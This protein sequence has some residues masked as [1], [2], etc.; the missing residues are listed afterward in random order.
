[1]FSDV[2]PLVH[3]RYLRFQRA[4][5]KETEAAG[6]CVR[7]EDVVSVPGRRETSRPCLGLPRGRGDERFPEDRREPLFISDRIVVAGTSARSV[8]GSTRRHDS[9][10]K[11]N[12]SSFFSS[13]VCG[14]FPGKGREFFFPRVSPASEIRNSWKLSI[15]ELVTFL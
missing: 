10:A 9:T 11:T 8:R 5:R 14:C 2:F 15:Q 7:D 1:M 3:Y 12:V 13:R 6:A 4:E